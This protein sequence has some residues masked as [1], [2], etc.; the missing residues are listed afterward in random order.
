MLKIKSVDNLL[1]KIWMFFLAS[2]LIVGTTSV[3]YTMY[4]RA[5]IAIISLSLVVTVLINILLINNEK[6]IKPHVFLLGLI[7]IVSS[8]LLPIFW[9]NLDLYYIYI[10]FVLMP[11]IFLYIFYLIKRGKLYDFVNIFVKIC[12]ILA[13]LSIFIWIFG[14]TLRLIHP[15]GVYNFVWGNRMRSVNTY[16]K[17]YFETQNAGLN[18]GNIHFGVKNNSIFAEAPMCCYIYICASILNELFIKNKKY[19]YVFIIMILSTLT[20]TGQ[21]YTILLVLY[22]LFNWSPQKKYLYRIKIF[23]IIILSFIGAFLIFSMLD[24]KSSTISGNDRIIHMSKEW[25]CFKTCPI[26]GAGF[27]VFTNGTSNSFFAL[28]ADGGI[29]LWGLYY[30]PLLWCIFNYNKET[31]TIKLNCIMYTMIFSFTASQYTPI[32]ILMTNILFLQGVYGGKSD[33]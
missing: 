8:I 18:F 22:I 13:C 29:L 28:L 9:Q 11:F 21:L 12:I 25:N 15:T 27:D 23:M 3:Y 20:T 17:I 32:A 2:I 1:E 7:Y 16:F 5:M 33:V 24:L 30:C 6:N 14:S 4:T 19:R 26:Y 31:K 10:V